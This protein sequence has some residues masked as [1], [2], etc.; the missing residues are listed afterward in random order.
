M[1]LKYGSVLLMAEVVNCGKPL[2]AL[3]LFQLCGDTDK[4]GVS[5]EYAFV[6]L[7]NFTE[8]SAA[9]CKVQVYFK[10]LR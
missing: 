4:S 8:L 3:I 7:I 6:D 1:S 9:T 2:V 5:I 10:C